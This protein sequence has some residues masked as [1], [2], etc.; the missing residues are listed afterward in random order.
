MKRKYPLL[1][2][3]L[4]V[5]VDNFGYSLL[6]NLLGPLLLK[7]EY[8]LMAAATSIHFKNAMLALI[9][10]IFPLAQFFAAPLIGEFADIHGRKKAFVLSLLGIVL[11]FVLSAISIMIQSVWLL[12][13]SR[14]VTGLFAG[15]ICVCMAAIADLSADEKTRGK[16]FS[17]L[18]AVY[19]VSWIS[20]MM[21]G[22]YLAHPNLFGDFGPAFAFLFSAF[23]T[24]VTLVMLLFMYGDT[25]P[26]VEQ[27]RF[28]FAR[29]IQNIKHVLLMRE[30][31][32]YFAVFFSWSLSWIMAIQWYPPYSMEV[33]GVGIYSFTT[34]YIVMGVTWVLGSLFSRYYLTE[35]LRAITGSLLGFGVMTLCLLVMQLSSSFIIFSILF[36]AASFFSVFA[37]SS[38]LN[39][40]SLSA[41]ADVQG[42]MMGLTQ[43]AQSVAFVCAS[44]LAFF[45]TLYTISVLFYFVF[46]VSLI[47]FLLL[48]YKKLQSLAN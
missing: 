40:V 44:T 7:P 37:M 8:G 28:E 1:P 47:G 32:V 24:F 10:G 41:P 14:L 33:Y 26:K 15:N 29:G 11:G 43:S 17:M 27:P 22:G 30:S 16:N 12:L 46:I 3:Y 36:S 4:V 9:F 18:T 34:W 13:F 5:L 2:V 38:S 45:V 42:K 6:F 25:A 31:R 48:L 39:L 20:A 21:V 23:L 35:N 19:G